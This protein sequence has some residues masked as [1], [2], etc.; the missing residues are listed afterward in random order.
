MTTLHP[1]SFLEPSFLFFFHSHWFKGSFLFAEVSHPPLRLW[2]LC[3]PRALKTCKDAGV[4]VTTETSACMCF[5]FLLSLRDEM[6]WP[7]PKG[8]PNCWP[9]ATSP[10]AHTPTPLGTLY[11]LLDR[12]SRH[13]FPFHTTT[14]NAPCATTFLLYPLC[15]SSAQLLLQ[16]THNKAPPA[17][18]PGKQAASLRNFLPK[19]SQAHN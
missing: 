2:V 12:P 13:L 5:F 9:S 17:S 16:H 6:R 19:P 10:P 1:L 3:L 15:P 11:P 7:L 18:P 8:H 14:C 4:T